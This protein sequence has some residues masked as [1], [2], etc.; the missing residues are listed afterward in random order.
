MSTQ[1]VVTTPAVIPAGSCPEAEPDS[2]AVR[3]L[4]VQLF[5]PF[6]SMLLALTYEESV[7]GLAYVMEEA[8]VDQV[9]LPFGLS[10][11]ENVLYRICIQRR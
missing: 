7:F 2:S 1:R 3:K 8:G 4:L 9:D 11:N 5:D 6:G 10:A